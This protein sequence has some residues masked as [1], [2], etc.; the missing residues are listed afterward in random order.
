M[1]T[2]KIILDYLNGGLVRASDLFLSSGSTGNST[3]PCCGWCAGID[4]PTQP[5]EPG[6]PPSII[7]SVTDLN[8][9]PVAYAA[10]ESST[11]GIRIIPT[12][13]TPAQFSLR[14][15]ATTAAGE[16]HSRTVDIVLSELSFSKVPVSNQFYTV[17]IGDING[18]GRKDL[19]GST[20][21]HDGSFTSPDPNSIGLSKLFANDRTHRDQRL[22]DLNNDGTL[23]LIANTYAASVPG[24]N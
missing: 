4:C 21:N 1:S 16:S 9:Q 17:A 13:T 15:T 20:Q 8:G 7:F 14:V 22:V 23:D 11:K 18:D 12:E 2:E 24:S 3:A 5:P 19:A 10:V 6:I